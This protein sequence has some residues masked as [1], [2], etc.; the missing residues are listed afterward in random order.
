LIV[1]RLAF[2]IVKQVGTMI[3]QFSN[4]YTKTLNKK[5]KECIHE[6]FKLN[7]NKFAAERIQIINK[8]DGCDSSLML[9][10]IE[11]VIYSC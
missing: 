9:Y 4:S 3:F 1:V 2:T 6:D 11:S 5:V 8:K 10:I 7:L